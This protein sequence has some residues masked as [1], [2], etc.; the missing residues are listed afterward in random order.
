[1]TPYLHVGSIKNKYKLRN[2]FITPYKTNSVQKP[3][4]DKI[5]S[6]KEK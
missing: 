2:C 1:M 6:V 5:N 4:A 3:P